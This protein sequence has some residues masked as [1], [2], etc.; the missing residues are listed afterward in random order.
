MIPS[1]FVWKS[2][3]IQA[4]N[5]DFKHDHEPSASGFFPVNA[6]SLMSSKHPDATDRQHILVWAEPQHLEV[7]LLHHKFVHLEQPKS[8]ECEISSGQNEITQG[9]L[10]LRAASAGLRLHTADA[11]VKN[12][13]INIMDTSQSGSIGFSSLTANSTVRIKLP[14]SLEGDLGEIVVRVEVIYNTKRGE[15]RYVSHLKLSVSLPVAVNVQ[16]TFIGEI[17]FSR[18]TIG[19]ASATPLKILRTYIENDSS[20]IACCQSLGKTE[21]DLFDRQPLSLVVK[22]QRAANRID[23]KQQKLYLRIEYRSLDQDIYQAVEECFLKSLKATAYWLYSRLLMPALQK[24]LRTSLATQDFE[25]IGLSRETNLGS[26]E[27]YSWS[28]IVAAI[29][30]TRREELTNWLRNWYEVGEQ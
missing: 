23:G 18:F 10:L 30:P 11:E 2:L 14:Y 19:T 24:A 13:L 4:G 22:I 3:S 26:F 27:E 8:I 1:A 9:K 25:S 28:P 29:S 15:F 7:R 6:K 12:K 5:I 16:D 21:L 20:L 17:L